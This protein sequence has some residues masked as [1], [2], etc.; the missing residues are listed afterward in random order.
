MKLGA[1]LALSALLAVGTIAH[2]LSKYFSNL[3]DPKLP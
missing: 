3:E 2:P 1:A